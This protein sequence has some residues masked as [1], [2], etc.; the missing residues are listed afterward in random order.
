MAQFGKRR[1]LGQHFLKDQSVISTIVDTTMEMAHENNCASLLEIG[2][3]RGALTEGLMDR[4]QKDPAALR[5]FT[6]CE[7]DNALAF[8]WKKKLESVPGMRIHHGDFLEL[9]EKDWLTQKP[10]AV[11]SNLPYA[12]GTAIFL[13]LAEHHSSI[14][15]MVLMFQAEVAKRLRAEPDT[16]SWGS[17]SIWTQNFWEVS[18]LLSVAPGAFAPPPEVDSEVAVFKPRTSPLIDI[19]NPKAWN[20]LLRACFAHRRKM[21]RSGLP[22]AGPLRNALELAGVNDTK[23][24][25]A[26]DWD[27]WK[28][29]YQAYLGQF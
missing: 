27:E 19:P 1:A 29:L 23:R 4:F 12:S 9:E 22:K 13:K 28:K 17:L 3:G 25:E 18:K 11:V 24:A 10:M 16:K 2:P 7:R 26:L 5:E 15:V 20:E 21:L 6:L 8:E 14:P